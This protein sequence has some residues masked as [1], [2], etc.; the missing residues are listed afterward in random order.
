V[1]EWHHAA[2]SSRFVCCHAA[3]LL[4]PL[5]GFTRKEGID[6]FYIQSTAVYFYLFVFFA[7]F[8]FLFEKEKGSAVKKGKKCSFLFIS[9][10]HFFMSSFLYTS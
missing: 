4:S 2:K 1:I 7:F 8:V 6:F 9:F 3:V 5:V 10:I